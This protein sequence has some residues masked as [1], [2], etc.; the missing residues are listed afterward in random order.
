MSA[1]SL[2]DELI[3][4]ILSPKPVSP[5]ADPDS[6]S[7]SAYL[8]VCKSWLRVATPLLYHV[9]VIRSK[10]QAKAL[11][12]VLAKNTLLGSFIRRL[13]VEGGYGA[14][15]GTIFK[16]SPN[17]TDLHMTLEV[18]ASDSTSGLCK[19][20]PLISPARLILQ[21]DQRRHTNQMTTNLQDALV[22]SILKWERLIM[23]EFPRSSNW[24]G[25]QWTVVLEALA[26]AKRLE[27]VKIDSSDLFRAHELLNGCPLKNIHLN[28]SMSPSL[29]SQLDNDPQMK[30]LV[31]LPDPPPANVTP[32]PVIQSWEFSR[33]PFIS[34][35]QEAQESI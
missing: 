35:S 2:P 27:R 8:L 24:Y 20:L 6:E 14:P 15:L 22:K 4:E 28:N 30:A 12:L 34:A 9:V 26:K 23:V 33:N 5:F 21:I 32:Q 25:N 13:R 17:I 31:T 3:S 18:W 10:A 19:G 16:C 29:S 1:A 11:G 7:T